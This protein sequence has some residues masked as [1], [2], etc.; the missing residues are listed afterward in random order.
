MAMK[1]Q[2]HD[3]YSLGTV[4]KLTGVSPE[5]LRAWE[6]RYGLIS[7]L[8]TSGGTRRYTLENIE[9][10]RLAKL[11]VDRGHRIGKVA[12]WSEE[13][14]R[15]ESAPRR[16]GAPICFDEILEAGRRLNY[17]ECQRLLAMYF[18]SLG[19]Q[20]F[21][22]ELA[23][24]L[25]HRI[26]ELWV[27]DEYSIASEHLI[28]SVLR[29]LLGSAIQPSAQSLFGPTIVF[30]TPS[31][32]RHELGLLVASVAAMGAGANTIHLGVDIPS[33]DIVKAAATAKA[34]VLGLSIVTLSKENANSR[35]SEIR[36]DLASDIAIW[37]GGRAACNVTPTDGIEHL[38]SVDELERRIALLA[39]SRR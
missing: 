10:I 30:A 18:G 23:V 12:K 4:S 15:K 19:P 33:S 37:L 20:R 11:A 27:S 22:R 7:P 35:V 14:L 25:T 24:P 2:Q 5:L 29:S 28:T 38:G 9:K 32:E 39:A 8:R 13:E 6:R 34:Q 16:A 3:T 17:S 1:D 31:Q 36:G 26:G 21:A